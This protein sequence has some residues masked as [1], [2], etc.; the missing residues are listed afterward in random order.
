[1]THSTEVDLTDKKKTKQLQK[2]YT[3]FDVYDT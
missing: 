1:M 2:E 3:P